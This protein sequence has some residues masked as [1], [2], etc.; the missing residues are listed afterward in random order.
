MIKLRELKRYSA[1]I[2]TFGLLLVS[3]AASSQDADDGISILTLPI[4]LVYTLTVLFV[5]ASIRLGSWIS[6]R[7]KKTTEQKTDPTITSVSGA[8]MGLLAFI[9]AF[10]FNISMGRYDTRKMLFIDQVNAIETFYR[11]SELLPE[12]YR[13]PIQG[14]LMKLVD[15]RIGII[16]HSEKI[17]DMIS[18]TY[19]VHDSL[20]SVLYQVERDETID[21]P[22][23]NT[24]TNCMSTLIE[25]HNKR[26]TVSTFYHIAL[27]LWI[28]LFTLLG[29]AMIGVG[30]LLGTH[31]PLN[32]TLVIILALS[33]SSII[34]IIAALDRS[35]SHKSG[36]QFNHQSIVD[37]KARLEKL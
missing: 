23:R 34:I 9:L 37:L 29:F 8:L 20:W 31:L 2:L 28:A 11:N 35:G 22:F 13:T 14:H 19:P 17:K 18:Q 15:L 33:F 1:V 36:I 5:I 26:T 6:S 21:A 10:T 12:K 27:P 30:Y 32:W 4:W 24:L 25:V 7:K 16:D 3:V